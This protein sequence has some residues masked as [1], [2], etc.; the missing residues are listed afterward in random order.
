MHRAMN[1]WDLHRGGALIYTCVSLSTPSA[2]DARSAIG[3]RWGSSTGMIERLPGPVLRRAVWPRRAVR[4]WRKQGRH[5]GAAWR[6]PGRRR[7]RFRKPLFRGLLAERRERPLAPAIRHRRRRA[8]GQPRVMA[9]PCEPCR[10]RRGR[11]ISGCAR[12][13]QSAPPTKELSQ[14]CLTAQI[15]SLRNRARPLTVK[16]EV[17]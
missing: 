5:L 13:R 16:N 12:R 17:N 1:E 15:D 3:A 11:A 4:S 14:A 6:S 7:A 10:P 8:P 2:P 9:P